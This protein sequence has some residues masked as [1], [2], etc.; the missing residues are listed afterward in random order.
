MSALLY[1][2]LAHI[3]LR[4]THPCTCAC[5]HDSKAKCLAAQAAQ[6]EDLLVAAEERL[7]GESA[8][9]APSKAQRRPNSS[10]VT[11]DEPPSSPRPRLVFRRRSKPSGWWLWDL[12]SGAGG[13]PKVRRQRSTPK[14]VLHQIAAETPS[15]AAFPTAD[16]ALE[17]IRRTLGIELPGQRRQDGHGDRDGGGRAGSKSKTDGKSKADAAAPLTWDLLVA[18][19]EPI[20]EEGAEQEASGLLARLGARGVHAHAVQVLERI[21]MLEGRGLE[22]GFRVPASVVTLGSA[23][24]DME[25][26]RVLELREADQRYAQDK[27]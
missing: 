22:A 19:F 16:L 23:V 15:L 9:R 5:M 4:P 25:A 24:K 13:G 26:R 6:I 2:S 12:L 17:I 18:A 27:A 21:H 14:G 20:S 10:T 11:T 1:F 7:D 3:I 8:Q